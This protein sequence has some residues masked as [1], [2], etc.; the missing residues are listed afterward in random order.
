MGLEK[1]MMVDPNVWGTEVAEDWGDSSLP[2]STVPWEKGGCCSR[3]LSWE[4]IL[5]SSV[6]LCRQE[7]APVTRPLTSL[8]SI[9]QWSCSKPMEG[10]TRLRPQS[11]MISARKHFPRLQNKQGSICTNS[12]ASVRGLLPEPGS[13]ATASQT[14]LSVALT[15]SGISSP[16]SCHKATGLSFS[17]LMARESSAPPEPSLGVHLK[18]IQGRCVGLG[19]GDGFSSSQTARQIGTAVWEL[20]Q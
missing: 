13:E 20:R 1:K 16:L 4:T 3:A 8:V 7:T 14:I 18:E 6:G 15:A 2:L 9:W 11:S 12:T 10:P 19:V 5:S 17:P